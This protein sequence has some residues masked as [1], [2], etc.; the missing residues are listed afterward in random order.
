[1]ILQFLGYPAIHYG[2]GG[3]LPSAPDVVAELQ[4]DEVLV[5]ECT[6]VSPTSEKIQ[7]LHSNAL[8]LAQ[9]LWNRANLRLR[10]VLFHATPHATVS[11][12]ARQKSSECE[13]GLI[14]LE[15]LESCERML[16]QGESREVIR[17]FLFDS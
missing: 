10:L 12:G 16:R 6:V 11:P 2:R 4:E 15:K 5:G 8:S 7:Q 14:G 1:M 17:R 3:Q 13:V 9:G